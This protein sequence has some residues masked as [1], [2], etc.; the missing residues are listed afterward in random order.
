MAV[1]GVACSDVGR[2][3]ERSDDVPA[4]TGFWK[5][6]RFA[7]KRSCRSGAALDPAYKLIAN[8]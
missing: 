1:T 6:C 3:E 5:R 7:D 4:V 8:C 2:T